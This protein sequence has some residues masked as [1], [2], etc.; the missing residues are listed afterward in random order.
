MSLASAFLVLT[1]VWTVI[2]AL[3]Y[4]LKWSSN[5]SLLPATTTTGHTRRRIWSADSTT[6]VVLKGLHLRVQ[7]TALNLSHDLLA[8][9]LA[10]SQKAY[11][12]RALNHL[13]DA[14]A[15]ISLL[16]MLLAL[17]FLFFTSA[18]SAVS[19]IQKLYNS[20]S[21][22]SS[23]VSQGLRNF[24]KRTIDASSSL[25]PTNDPFIKPIATFV[26]FSNV[27][28]EGLIPRARARI[29]AAGAFH[30]ILLWGLL[31]AIGYARLGDL[32]WSIGYKDVSA[33]GRVVVDVDTRSPLYNHLPLG[34]LITALDDISLG[35]HNASYDDGWSSYLN[36]NRHEQSL[37]WC[38]SL[39]G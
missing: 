39:P 37:G 1:L 35:S 11:L 28:L 14:G 36:R 31:L 3:H 27:T 34:S 19:I 17:G 26:T 13:Y 12:R 21:P 5:H 23:P 7:T 24:G 33:Q 2:Y 16:G 9:S 15:V 29:I 25:A 38:A 20:V 32:F 6:T 4:L 10:S 8:S 22:A 18:T 30:N